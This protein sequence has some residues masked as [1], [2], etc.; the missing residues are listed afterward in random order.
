VTEFEDESY[1]ELVLENW[2]LTDNFRP[3][4]FT[5]LEKLAQSLKHNH[6]DVWMVDFLGSRPSP[7]ANVL[8]LKAIHANHDGKADAALQ[9]ATLAEQMYLRSGNH[10]GRLRSE[11]ERVYALRRLS[12]ST[13]CRQ[14]ASQL[15][16]SSFLAGYHWIG[17]QTTIEQGSCAGMQADA[18]TAWTLAE[19][20]VKKAAAAKYQILYLRALGLRGNLDMIEGRS[21]A[22]WTNNEEGLER[23]WQ[24]SF[25]EERAFQFYYNLQVDAEKN[26]A[27]YLALVLQ[28]E[29]LNMIAKKARFD[30]EA[31]AHFRMAGAAQSVGDIETAHTEIAL[32]KELISRLEASDARDLYEAYC[33]IGLARLSLQSASGEEA[34]QHLARATPVVAR[35]GNFMLRLEARKTWADLHRFFGDLENEKKDLGEIMAIADEGFKSLKSVTD[36]W[37]WRRVTEETYRRLLEIELTS[38]HSSA[39]SLGF[40]EFYRQ[41]ESSPSLPPMASAERANVAHLAEE[42]ASILHNK[43]FL[44]YAVLTTTVV[45]WIADDR[46]I[47]ELKL[48]VKPAE[49]RNES[50][51]FY[52]LCSDPNSSLE[53]VNASASRLYGWLIAPIQG[54]IPLDREIQIEPDG[55]LGLVPWA[56]LRM[57]DGS[58]WGSKRIMAITPGLFLGVMAVPSAN[59]PIRNVTIAIPNSLRLNGQN[60]L[61]PA[62]ADSEAAELANLYPDVKE[63]RGN[64]VTVSNIVKE[65]PQ[66]DIFEFAG[67]AVTR[68]HGGELVVQGESGAEM[69]SGARLATLRLPR[70]S[71]VVLSACSTGSGRDVDR[72]PNG[73]VRSLLNAGGRSVVATRWDVDSR[74][75]AKGMQQFYR[76]FKAGMNKSHALQAA[77][78]ELQA[79]GEFSHPYY[80]AGIELFSPN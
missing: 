11:F 13:E 54:E 62:N 33:E 42:R 58:Y 70:T 7:T 15:A 14:I 75:T 32:Y 55:F 76:S 19:K 41:L 80:W 68:E 56:A 22:S 78:E 36:R 69:V 66:A 27:I 29:T 21:D 4:Q 20:A 25:P 64:A 24:A 17:I 45:A 6:G 35:T 2:L 18:D 60:Y 28:R 5:V 31:M 1:Q 77:R 38:S 23:F 30:F 8:L 63:L 49:L 61:Q 79:K 74:A 52:S 73:L 37:R 47:R 72:D 51:R 43:S 46:G 12:K 50:L 10:A 53:K 67:H 44:S 65:L 9:T 57:P 26:H 48:P 34:R 16:G 59:E 40:W 39:H 71:L 3:A